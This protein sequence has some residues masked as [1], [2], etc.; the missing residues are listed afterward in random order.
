MPGLA[1][2]AAPRARPTP[3]AAR[4]LAFTAPPRTSAPLTIGAPHEAA[5]QEADRV[6]ARVLR[7]LVPRAGELSLAG[8]RVADPRLLVHSGGCPPAGASEFPTHREAH[9]AC[10]VNLRRLSGE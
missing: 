8:P 5:E 6:A 2:G 1:S 4:P 9:G 7:L 3:R 10:G